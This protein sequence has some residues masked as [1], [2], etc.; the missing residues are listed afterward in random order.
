MVI[1]LFCANV[2]YIFF[3]NCYSLGDGNSFDCTQRESE[4]GSLLPTIGCSLDMNVG[5]EDQ[6]EF[7]G[8]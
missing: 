6:F 1:G 5:D 3:Q 7:T 2:F 8:M 4:N